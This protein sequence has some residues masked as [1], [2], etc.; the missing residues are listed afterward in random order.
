MHSGKP[1][2]TAGGGTLRLGMSI[3]ELVVAVGLMVIIFGGAYLSYSSIF[4]TLMNAS[5]RDA[6]VSLLN[7]E[8]EIARNLPYDQMGTIGGIPSGILPR[9]KTV[10]VNGVDFLVV[11]TIR[12]IDDPFDGT[13]FGVGQDAYNDGAPN[14]MWGD[15]SWGAVNDFANTEVV[16]RG[17]SAA[18]SVLTNGGFKLGYGN[19]PD[20]IDPAV[21][22]VFEFAVYSETSSTMKVR[23]EQSYPSS[24]I[25][26]EVSRSIVPG[27]NIIS[28]PMSELNPASLKIRAVA[29]F[30]SSSGTYTWYFDEIRF[31]GARDNA[32]ADYKMIE[33]ETYCIRC[34]RSV[35]ITL[36]ATVAP[37]NLE[38]TGSS[39][40]LFVHAIDANGKPLSGITVHLENASVT[41]TVDLEDTTN[42]QGVLQIVGV[43]PSAQSYYL[44]V[45]SQGYSSDKTYPIGAP[46]NPNP[47]KPHATVAVGIVTDITF[48]IDLV[49]TLQFSA[50][51]RQCA[52]LPGVSVAVTSTKLIGTNPDVAKFTTSTRTDAS[53]TAALAD[54][55]WD[56]YALSVASSSLAMVGAIPDGPLV[57][58]P[59]TAIDRRY[60]FAPAAPKALAVRTVDAV[61]GAPL[62]GASV[63]VGSLA[64]Q[65]TGFHTLIHTDWSGGAYSGASAGMDAQSVP[66]SFLLSS[67]AG[68]YTTTT[69]W[70][71]S[72]TFDTGSASTT[73]GALSWDATVPLGTTARF[74]IATN[75]DAA[76]WNYVGPDGTSGTYFTASGTAVGTSHA[77]KRYARYKTWLSTT[78]SAVTPIVREISLSYQSPCVPPEVAY[79]D[80]LTQSSYQVSVF[81]NGYLPA[82]TTAATPSSWQELSVPLTPQ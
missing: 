9:Q 47:L 37:P 2:Y 1:W 79:F 49:S 44:S 38:A 45:S 55:E 28:I 14:S 15:W 82:T 6:A 61:S 12:N 16:Y 30:P 17:T 50:L 52:P 8:I 10:K 72:N 39:G 48:A 53:G 71:E 33:V 46:E 26:P 5:L 11:T 62:S 43:P 65:L 19:D 66:G 21:Y 77:S 7:R 29:I 22:T 74:Q 78:E 57:V 24:V 40:S 4:D 64:P 76:T 32:P 34:A 23:V 27:W 41:P 51:T 58:S 56:T 60:I 63:T 3:I 35:P 67:G 81:T 18:K 59:N 13:I 20:H 42:A 70:L 54:V 73:F 69:E 36:T 75:N 68:G 80:G 31:V 25:G